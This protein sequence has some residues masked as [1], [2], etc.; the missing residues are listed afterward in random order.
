MNMI[1]YSSDVV[2]INHFWSLSGKMLI[3]VKNNRLQERGQL[4]PR[5]SVADDFRGQSCPRSFPADF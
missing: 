3:T 1:D 2:V 4:C 5:V